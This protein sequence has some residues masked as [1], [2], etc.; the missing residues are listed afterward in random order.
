MKQPLVTIYS[1][2]GCHLCEN[3]EKSL[4]TLVESL[5]FTLEVKLID[6]RKELEDLYGQLIPV[7]HVNGEYFSHFRVD[8]EEFKS[9]LEKHRQHQ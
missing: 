4:L 8:I 9:F 7:I 3:A 2:T 5:D 6:Q 1:R